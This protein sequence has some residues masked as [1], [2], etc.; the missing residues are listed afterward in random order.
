M[1]SPIRGSFVGAPWVASDILDGAALLDGS[2]PPASAPETKLTLPPS[3]AAVSP[4]AALPFSGGDTG[5]GPSRLQYDSP[6][7]D[8]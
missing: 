1:L 2:R 8:H 4:T 5:A 7:D 6:G 3:R